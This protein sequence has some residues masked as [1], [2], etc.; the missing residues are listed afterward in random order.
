MGSCFPIGPF[1][2]GRAFLEAGAQTGRGW[3]EMFLPELDIQ[4]VFTVVKGK[5]FGL[6]ICR[7]GPALVKTLFCSILSLQVGFFEVLLL[8]SA[9]CLGK[10]AL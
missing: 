5:S 2:T 1:L 7:V 10:E 8:D 6:C 4:S 3:L 9:S